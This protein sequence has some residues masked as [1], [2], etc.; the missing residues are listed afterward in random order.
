MSEHGQVSEPT[1]E[2]KTGRPEACPTVRVNRKAAGAVAS[3]HPWIFSSDVTD[4]GQAQPGE[5]VIVVDPRGRSLGMAHY[6]SASQIALR[7]LAR[8]VRRDRAILFAAARARRRPI[9]DRY[10]CAGARCLSRG[11]RRSAICCRR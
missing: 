7:M 3:G 10:W 8:Q 9:A 2:K 5:A 6:S 4:R 1:T 11:A